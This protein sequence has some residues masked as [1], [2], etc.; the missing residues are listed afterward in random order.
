[1]LSFNC[2]CLNA[3]GSSYTAPAD[4]YVF[5]QD[6]GSQPFSALVLRTIL[7]RLSLTPG[8]SGNPVM[9]LLM[10]VTKDTVFFEEYVNNTGENRVFRFIY[11][12]GAAPTE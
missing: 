9:S 8:S 1:M 2:Y 11:A 5:F 12:V 3:S 4:G 7:Y 10:S 6:T